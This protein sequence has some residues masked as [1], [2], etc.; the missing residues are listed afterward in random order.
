LTQLLP[1]LQNKLLAK[2]ELDGARGSTPGLSPVGACETHVANVC[3]TWKVPTAGATECTPCVPRSLARVLVSSEPASVESDTLIDVLLQ[4]QQRDAFAQQRV[5]D[6]KQVKRTRSRRDTPAWRIDDKEVLRYNGR[7][8]VPE[9][10]AIRQEILSQ[11][12]DTRMAGHFGARRT[13]EL[14][15]RLYYWP[16]LDK[17]VQEY[18]KTC[19]ICQRNKA[20]RHSKYGKLA[21]LPIPKDIFEEVSLDFVTGLPPAKDGAGCVFDA[22]LVIVDRFSKMAIY[23]PALKTWDVKQFAEAYFEQVILR[24]GIQKGIVSNRGS[25]FTSAF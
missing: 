9:E 16:S 18:V 17:D 3:R 13:Q 8:Y 22:V 5:A 21:P 6:T 19:A 20:P 10:P 2:V 1:T 4:L 11:S 15:S 14:I 12:H 24:Y 7:I 25:I 23:L